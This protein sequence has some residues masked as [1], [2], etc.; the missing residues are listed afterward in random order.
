M[1][2]RDTFESQS[3]ALEDHSQSGNPSAEAPLE[4][5][6]DLKGASLIENAD[7][8]LNRALIWLAR[9]H[10][11]IQVATWAVVIGSVAIGL[12]MWL[13]GSMDLDRIADQIGYWAAFYLNLVGAASIVLPV[14]GILAVCFAAAESLG[15]NIFLLGILGGAGAALGETTSYLVGYSGQKAVGN[16]PGYGKIQ[17]LMTEHGSVT[18]FALAV[19]PNPIFDVAGIAAGALRYPY[20]KFLIYIFIGK[21]IRMII[22]AYACRESIGWLEGFYK[23]IFAGVG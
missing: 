4:S 10:L 20:R 23:S 16:V 12:A 17:R 15:L 18:I 8:V 13:S 6:S 9:H 1:V 2:P 14:P 5:L 7:R 19:I 3:D 22:M 21:T 11:L